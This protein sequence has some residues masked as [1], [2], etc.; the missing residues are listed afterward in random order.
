ME[1]CQLPCCLLILVLLC[2]PCVSLQM[3]HLESAPRRIPQEGNRHEVF[4]NRPPLQA[5]PMYLLPLTS[6]RPR[7]WLADS[8][9]WPEWSPR[10]VVV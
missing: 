1:S 7:G 9:G 5:T 10:R 3:D 6:I 8:G 4:R 2:A